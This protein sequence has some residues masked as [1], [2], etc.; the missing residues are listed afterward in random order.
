L[1]TVDAVEIK[2][3]GETLEDGEVNEDAA[4]K[5]WLHCALES[6]AVT[7]DCSPYSFVIGGS[8]YCHQHIDTQ[9]NHR[10]DMHS[11]SIHFTSFC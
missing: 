10:A 4:P 11:K 3:D 6:Q 7:Q 8:A 9:I 1:F 5:G 2:T